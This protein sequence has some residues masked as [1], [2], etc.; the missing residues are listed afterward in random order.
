MILARSLS[1][2]AQ[3]QSPA[4]R[5]SSLLPYATTFTKKVI[6]PIVACPGDTRT[7]LPRRSDATPAPDA[8]LSDCPE[9]LLATAVLK[10]AWTDAR[11]GNADALAFWR[12]VD[13]SAADMWCAAAGLPDATPQRVVATLAGAAGVGQLGLWGE[14]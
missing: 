12:G 9:A 10:L 4:W 1:G 7:P 13:A 3:E 8:R 6:M 14:A 5:H 11:H 2:L